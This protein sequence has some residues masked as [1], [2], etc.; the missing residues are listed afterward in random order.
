MGC[1]TRGETEGVEGSNLSAALLLPMSVLP[2]KMR[3]VRLNS[4]VEREP[5]MVMPLGQVDHV[6]NIETLGL[7]IS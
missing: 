6:F 1:V 2:S 5:N 3:T 4:L 7:E